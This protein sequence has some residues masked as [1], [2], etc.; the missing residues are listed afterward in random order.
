MFNAYDGCGEE[1]GW[2]TNPEND[3]YTDTR[4]YDT[5]PQSGAYVT[6]NTF[7]AYTNQELDSVSICM[8]KSGIRNCVETGVGNEFSL[9]Y[10]Y[11]GHYNLIASRR[12]YEKDTVMILLT[13]QSVKQNFRL[14]PR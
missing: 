10:F 12:G 9:Y 8:V 2:S 13:G 5:R 3:G 11:T 1:G 7:D 14:K 4:P 6:G